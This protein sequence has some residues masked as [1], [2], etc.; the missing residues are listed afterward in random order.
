[1]S[2]FI[3]TPGQ[4]TLGLRYLPIAI[5]SGLVERCILLNRFTKVTSLSF[6]TL[7]YII[8]HKVMNDKLVIMITNIIYTLSTLVPRPSPLWVFISGE[9]LGTRLLS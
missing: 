8:L 1:M 5:D 6:I 3:S 4:H 9:G 7:C 2:L